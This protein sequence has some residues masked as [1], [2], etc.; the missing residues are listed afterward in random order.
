MKRKIFYIVTIMK[1]NNIN[2]KEVW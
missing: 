1:V 2:L